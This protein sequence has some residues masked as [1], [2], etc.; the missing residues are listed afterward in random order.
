MSA[1]T[2]ENASIVQTLFDFF[3]QLSLLSINNEKN[4]TKK[5]KKS[6][7]NLMHKVTSG[8]STQSN[9]NHDY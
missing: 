8:G 5:E 1:S 9:R 4:K 7:A 2:R 3:V 6:H